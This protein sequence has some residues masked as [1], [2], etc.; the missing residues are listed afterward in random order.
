MAECVPAEMGRAART[1]GLEKLDVG[2]NLV[3]ADYRTA[4]RRRSLDTEGW[5]FLLLQ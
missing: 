2:T 3:C 1:V 4:G 5:G